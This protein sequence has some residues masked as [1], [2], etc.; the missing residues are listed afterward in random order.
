VLS[1][2]TNGLLR[3]IDR[4]NLRGALDLERSDTPG[5]DTGLPNFYFLLASISRISADLTEPKK[6]LHFT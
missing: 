6:A 2:T 4:L 1:P 3:E 5:L